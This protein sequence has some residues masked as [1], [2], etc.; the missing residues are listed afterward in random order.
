[1]ER[2]QA[3]IEKARARRDGETPPSTHSVPD[4][5]PA[6]FRHRSSEARNEVVGAWQDI[7]VFTPN[8]KHLVRNRILTFSGGAEATPFD[9]MRTRVLQQMQANGWR[10]LAITS[11]SGANGKTTIA[12]NLAFGMA[13]QQNQRVGL[14]ELDMRRPA[15]AQTIGLNERG[16]QFSRVLEGET[17]YS[18]QMRRVG[19][20]LAIGV[21]RKPVMRSTEL[22]RSETATLALKTI[23]TELDLSLMLFDM[24][25]MLLSD[26][27]QAFAG[28][29]D[30]ALVVAGAE[31]TTVADIDRCERDLAAQTNVLGVVLNKCR[32]TEEKYS[33]GYGY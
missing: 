10:R 19:G 25:P 30:C 26:D 32:Y 31:Q 28:E 11:P 9:M 13:R 16:L 18:A 2:I 27:M 1:M 14:I 23:E 6:T 21:G 20:N 5:A 15:L 17:S 4:S 7:P 8:A 24:P 33:Y 12:A 3:A 29:V 22:L